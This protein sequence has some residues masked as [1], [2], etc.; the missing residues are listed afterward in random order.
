MIDRI[1]DRRE[2]RAELSLYLD[3]FKASCGKKSG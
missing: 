2:L 1:V 3:F